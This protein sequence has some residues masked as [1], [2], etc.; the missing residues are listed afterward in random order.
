M[1]L[2]A[3][4]NLRYWN[5][6][7]MYDGYERLEMVIKFKENRKIFK[8]KLVETLTSVFYLHSPQLAL[9]V[10]EKYDSYEDYYDDVE[11]IINNKEYLEEMA[12]KKI[13]SY[14]SNKDDKEWKSNRKNEISNKANS[15][16]SFEIK[17]K[18]N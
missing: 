11:S 2:L 4:V 6:E 17:V 5:G 18:I 3:T 15:L 10:R 9:D 1:E 7:S 13:K 12:V 14:F 16:P 8:T